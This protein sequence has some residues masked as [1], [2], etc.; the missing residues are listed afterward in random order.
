[1]VEGDD[2]LGGEIAPA[3]LVGGSRRPRR[4]SIELTIAMIENDNATVL[5]FNFKMMQL[6]FCAVFF[7]PAHAAQRSKW[8]VQEGGCIC[9]LSQTL[10]NGKI[11]RGCRESM[12]RQR[13]VIFRVVP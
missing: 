12:L 6:R 13:L 11:R 8:N 9:H 5:C 10:H 7:A 2:N 3:P 1:M 4:V